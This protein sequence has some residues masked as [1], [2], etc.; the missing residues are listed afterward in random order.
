M[1][2]I[3]KK[4]KFNIPKFF[5]SECWICLSCHDIHECYFIM[6]LCKN[7]KHLSLF[8]EKIIQIIYFIFLIFWDFAIHAKIIWA[9]TQMGNFQH[10]FHDCNWHAHIGDVFSEHFDIL[11]EFFQVSMNLLWTFQSYG[12]TVKGQKHKICKVAW[13]EQVCFLN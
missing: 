8:T 5:V 13:I 2:V 11:F 12:Q 3:A 4:D 9:R 10:F 1:K 6:K 7:S